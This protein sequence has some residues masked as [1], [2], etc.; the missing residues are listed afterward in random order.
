MEDKIKK[1]IVA[2]LFAC[3]AAPA[4]GLSDRDIRAACNNLKSGRGRAVCCTNLNCDRGN[5]PQKMMQDIL[6]CSE[7]EAKIRELKKSIE[8]IAWRREQIQRELLRY[9]AIVRVEKN[10]LEQC[11]GRADK[12]F[13]VCRS[14]HDRYANLLEVIRLDRNR[15]NDELTR[16]REESQEA[17]TEYF[18]CL[19]RVSREESYD[20]CNGFISR[21]KAARI[22]YDKLRLE[23]DMTVGEL[24][25]HWLH[26]YKHQQFWPL[27]DPLHANESTVE[28]FVPFDEYTKNIPREEIIRLVRWAD[29]ST[30]FG[31]PCDCSGRH[32]Y[33]EL[34]TIIDAAGMGRR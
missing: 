4:M 13:A 3:I 29:Q 15:T 28:V 21:E 9:A 19:G 10:N 17:R 26:T 18:L 2:F 20:N 14:Y 24:V 16:R 22:A 1:I 23:F 33:L 27:T 32:T 30:P 25:Q 34:R 12:A 6:R 11:L 31:T 5:D 7:H 8:D